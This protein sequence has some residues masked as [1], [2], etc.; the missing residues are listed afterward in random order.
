MKGYFKKNIVFILFAFGLFSFSSC[1][2]DSL[3]FPESGTGEQNEEIDI[4]AKPS[5]IVIKGDYNYGF[6][7]DWPTS[8]SSNLAKVVLEYEFENEKHTLE[9]EDFSEPYIL[10]VGADEIAFVNFTLYAISTSGKKSNPAIQRVQS[11]GLYLTEVA[12]SITVFRESYLEMKMRW[13]NPLAENFEL[14]YTIPT[15]QD[16]ATYKID[17][18]AEDGSELFTGLLGKN[19]ISVKL[20]D[21]LNNVVRKEISYETT[22]TAYTTAAQKSGWTPYTSSPYNDEGGFNVST[23]LDGGKGDWA[24]SYASGGGRN[25]EISVHFTE[26]RNTDYPSY[27]NPAQRNPEGPFN[28]IIVSKLKFALMEPDFGMFPETVKLIGIRENK[29][30]VEIGTYDP[31]QKNSFE[32]DLPNNTEKW[33]GFVVILDHPSFGNTAI[34]EVDVFGFGK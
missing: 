4:I 34:G 31:Q 9:F 24:N 16:S 26:R 2:K 11:K 33:I 5:N 27:D 10:D 25:K 14:E 17:L 1:T 12:N 30:Q 6:K 7:I 15:R 28:S 3:V 19:T 23:I 8:L 21:E 18:G 29:S 13:E 22:P 32:I 20:T